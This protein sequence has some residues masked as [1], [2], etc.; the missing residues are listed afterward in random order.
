[1]S[2]FDN[3]KGDKVMKSIRRFPLFKVVVL[4]IAAM[5]ASASPAHAQR[6][7]GTFSLAHKVRWADA[8]LPAGNY[9]FS[10]DSQN[11]P[12]RVTVRQI[13]GSM[14]AMLMAQEISD[15]KLGGSSTL[16]LR[17][18]GGQSVVSVLR[19]QSIGVAL[20]FAPP[21]LVMPV[22][23]TAGLVPLADSQTAK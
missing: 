13:G 18:E 14:V 4:A 3:H 19:L 1:V 23:E 9:E 17:E 7:T 11:W 8:V 6:T 5:G 22:A 21:K 20:Q 15:E 2:A 12:V 10:L 16:I